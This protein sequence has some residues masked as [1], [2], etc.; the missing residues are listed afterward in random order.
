MG[1]GG[2]GSHPQVIPAALQA[3]GAW[4]RP[5]PPA[6]DLHAS[7]YSRAHRTSARRAVRASGW[8]SGHAVK[9]APGPRPHARPLR[10]PAQAPLGRAV[11]G[12]E[13]HAGRPF[14]EPQRLQTFANVCKRL[15]L[16]PAAVFVVVQTFAPATCNH[17]CCCA[18]SC[19]QTL[20][21]VA[22]ATCNPAPYRRRVAGCRSNVS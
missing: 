1:F 8:R 4:P 15:P 16:Q 2:G 20:R 5:T 19:S 12:P 13:A 21:N 7:I 22:P 9:A 18:N 6:P 10:R 3:R 17:F 11:P 14:R